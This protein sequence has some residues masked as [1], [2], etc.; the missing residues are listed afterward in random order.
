MNVRSVFKSLTRDR[1][2][3]GSS[4]I[5]TVISVLSKVL[6][7]GRMVLIAVM[8]GAS[9]GMDSYYV[10]MG[11]LGLLFGT[12]QN[13]L[14]SAVL[15][16]LAGAEKEGRDRDLMATVFWI[17]T[18]GAL[19]V[20]IGLCFFALPYIR[21]FAMNFDQERLHTG[22]NMLLL[23][24]P[25]GVATIFNGFLVAWS[26]HRG[27]YTLSS[28]AMMP[29]NLVL[30]PSIALL[31]WIW[32]P[33]GLALSQS[34]AFCACIA[35]FGRMTRDFP[36]KWT[37][38]QWD[39]L[40]RVGGDSLM[41]LGLVGA[42]ALYQATD[43]F[44][45]SGLPVGNVSAISYSENIFNLPLAFA[46]SP[47][48]IYLSKSSRSVAERGEALGHLKG[49][50]SIG[51]AYFMPCGMAFFAIARPLVTLV[52]NYGAFDSHA[53]DLTAACLSAYSVAMPLVLWQTVLFR[54]IQSVGKL[55]M[56]LYW[57]YFSVLLNVGLDWY[58]APILGATGICMATS[59]VWFSSSLY[60]IVKLVP[61]LF[62]KILPSI[63]LQT[64]CA[65][66]WTLPLRYI[67]GGNLLSLVWIMPLLIL[68]MVVC[69]K[70]GLYRDLPETWKPLTVSR[71][72]LG[73]IKRIVLRVL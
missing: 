30:I 63:A 54:Y 47:L 34:L 49:A 6:G 15:P 45:A 14:E 70:L 40:K 28:V 64:V 65:L 27:K 62:A 12:V 41:C 73:R 43:R 32:G 13:T 48:L 50:L 29:L 55:K 60:Y 35:L 8:F 46:V 72:V 67:P 10:A 11:S 66:C 57:S 31:G 17:T 52:F 7:Y 51:W 25:W 5:M 4:A 26:T 1:S 68:H 56:V 23:L 3:L 71:L 39:L 24:L 19:P 16:L 21:I 53:T 38:V 20:V 2:A 42:G 44:F 58:L 9:A 37:T 18:L 36:L 59:F 33:Y 22:A 69:E 61:G